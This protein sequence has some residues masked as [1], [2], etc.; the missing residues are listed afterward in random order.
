MPENP[1]QQE[2]QFLI[3]LYNQG[4]LQAVVEEASAL[5]RRYPNAALL[6]EIAGAANA[7]LGR[8]EQA[9]ACFDETVRLEPNS[10][11][12]HNNRGIALLQLGR[13]EAAF[14]SFDKALQLRPDFAEAYDNRGT[15]LQ[16][17]KRFD[18]AL[19]SYEQALKLSPDY[20]VAHYNRG[21]V[22]RD[23]K[24]LSEAL[25]SYD[26]VL[27]LDSRHV[28]A[29]NNRGNVLWE[30]RRLDEALA[31]YSRALQLRPGYAEAYHNRGVALHDLK[32]LDDA[33]ADYDQALR[34]QPD[35]ADAYNNRG[36]ALQDLNRLDEALVSYDQA[37]RL[38]PA[39][40]EAFYNRCTAAARMCAWDAGD[41]A[42]LSERKLDGAV[43]PFAALALADDPAHQL[44]LARTWVKSKFAGFPSPNFKREARE[45][46]LRVGYFSADFQEH[47]VMALLARLLELHDRSR[48]EIH[49]FSYGM[50][51]QDA[52]RQ[53]L[54]DAVDAFHDVRALDDGAV[55]ELARSKHIDIALDLNGHTAA[56]RLGIFAQRAAPVQINYLG[57]PGTSG[58]N[59]IDYIIADTIVAP[60]SSRPWFS[61]KVISL[62]HSYQAND[63]RR[64]ISDRRFTRDELGLPEN[65]FV[66]CCFNN[67][68]KISAAEF[69]VWMSLLSAVEG[70]VLWLLK[71]NKWAEANLRR[72]AVARGVAPER[73][74]FAERAPAAEH[75]ARHRC[76]DLFLD[77]FNY[78]AHTTA[79]DAL[80]VGLPLVTKLG[81]SFAARVAGSLLSAIDMPELITDSVE[82]YEHLALE[83][84][85][86]PERLAAIRAKL[87]ANRLTTPLFDSERYARHI[88]RA[89]DLAYQRFADGLPPD[90]IDVEE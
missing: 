11:D 86:Q 32:R 59:F 30:M 17:L 84:A 78:N 57:Y 81:K 34:L 20:V 1:S 50:N 45:P 7:G 24:R 29:A 55:V 77:T 47:A 12:A 70:S 21:N 40:A 85:T 35:Y 28:E 56:G 82:A 13:L 69:D 88:E 61:E 62:P 66:F 43:A 58:A 72:E 19:A 16:E 71:D 54:T 39:S 73:L 89:F 46:K 51:P 79:S 33:I 8:L 74:V 68:F 67:S 80:W 42:R 36:I 63:N 90:H 14:V 5:L 87:A 38:R 23:M 3:G 49:A 44:E 37:L 18:E 27:R 83:L 4:R 26:V 52:M 48:F 53:R 10:A 6:H 15:V 76:A 9:A 22:L 31:S 75:L 64:D 41:A 60:A 2:V 25:A 65:G